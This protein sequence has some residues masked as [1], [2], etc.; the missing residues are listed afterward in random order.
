[1]QMTSTTSSPTAAPRD[2]ARWRTVDIVVASVM[3]V[4]FGLLFAAWNNFVYPTIS[5]PLSGSPFGPL[6]AGVWLLPGVVGGL[7]IRRAGAAFY[8]EFL[9]ATVSLFFGSSWGLTVVMSGVWQG[10]GA[11]LVFLL[12]AYRRWGVTAAVLAGMGAGLAMGIYESIVY[13]PDYSPSWKLAYIA[14]A[15]VTGAVVA[16][17]LGW[18]LARSL[19][20]TGA[21]APFASGRAQAEI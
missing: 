14:A 9:A 4:A 2:A 15:I 6:I 11:E 12:L 5:V 21:L 20:R 18:L 8:T 7:V 10:I 1:M 19:A 16:G 3:A 17:Y 13:V